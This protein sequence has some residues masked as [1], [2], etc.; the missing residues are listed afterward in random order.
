MHLSLNPCSNGIWSLT[1]NFTSGNHYVK[2]SLNPCSNG[3]WSLTLHS[4]QHFCTYRVLILVLME[5][6]LWHWQGLPYLNPPFCLNPCSNGIW[7]LTPMSRSPPLRRQ[8]LNPCSNG[9]WSLTKDDNCY[10]ELDQGL[11]PCS[12]GIWSLTGESIVSRRTPP[13]S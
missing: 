1:H 9:I 12:N 7:S 6:G 3:I 2:A 10:L 4:K 8:C 5:Y 11:N 13:L